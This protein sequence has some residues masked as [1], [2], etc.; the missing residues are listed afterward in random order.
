MSLMIDGWMPSVGS[1]RTRSFGFVTSARAMAS[2]CCWPPEKSP[3]PASQHVVEHGKERKDFVVDRPLAARPGGVAGYEVLAHR[4]ERE[5]L[6]PLRDI[7]KAGLGPQVRRHFRHVLVVPAD[8]AGS[9]HVLP[10]D[11]AQERRLADAVA[12]EN[13]Q[14]TAGLRLDRH[15][16][17]RLRRAV[18]K[19]DSV[20]G[21]HG[22]EPR[23]NAC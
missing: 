13:G 6:A 7:A 4:Q 16:P 3:P 20:D 12:A 1:S 15:G 2:C 19:I 5:N 23:S 8:R 10:D 17:Q 21:Q 18:E 14:N 11:G 9:R 22:A